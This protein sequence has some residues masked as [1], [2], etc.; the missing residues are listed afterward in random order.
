MP[1][2]LELVRTSPSSLLTGRASTNLMYHISRYLA[3]SRMKIGYHDSPRMR[4]PLKGGI[5][6]AV[7]CPFNEMDRHLAAEDGVEPTDR[8]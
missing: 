2:L 7:A 1:Y 5:W 6:D 4:E 8:H 3:R